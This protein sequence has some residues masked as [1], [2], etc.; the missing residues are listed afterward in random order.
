MSPRSWMPPAPPGSPEGREPPSSVEVRTRPTRSAG[1]PASSRNAGVR[2]RR[3]ARSRRLLDSG[4]K[5]TKQGRGSR[6]VGLG[7]VFPDDLALLANE[8]ALALEQTPSL[9]C[10]VHGDR[11][12][13]LARGL[14]LDD[15]GTLEAVERACGGRLR[16]AGGLGKGANGQRI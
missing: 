5:G 2:D 10:Q 14:A 15:A 9:R 3:W 1:R 8:F 7:Q 16:H 12:T 13:V 4:R 6:A 11:A